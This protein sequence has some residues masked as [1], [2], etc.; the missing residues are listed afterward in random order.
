V[1]ASRRPSTSDLTLGL[2]DLNL[3]GLA[4]HLNTVHLTIDAR[5]WVPRRTC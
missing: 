4:V 5:R 2:L 3:L 1:S